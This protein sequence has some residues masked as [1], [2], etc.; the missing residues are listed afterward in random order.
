MTFSEVLLSRVLCFVS[1]V[2]GFGLG[3]NRSSLS[4][5]CTFQNTGARIMTF[6]GGSYAR[7][8]NTGQDHSSSRSGHSGT[9]DG[10]RRRLKTPIRS[11]HDIE[12]DSAKFLKKATKHYEA[13]ALS[14]G[15]SQVFVRSK[16]V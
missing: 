4:P 7:F 1:R 5:L 13:L 6:L 3:S 12:K 10:R 9:W 15:L 11:W 14:R 2:F 16:Q 8:Q